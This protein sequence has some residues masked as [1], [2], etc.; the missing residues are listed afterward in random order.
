MQGCEEE[1]DDENGLTTFGNGGETW[2]EQ[3]G[4]PSRG[5][6]TALHRLWPAE[7][8]LTVLLF[9]EQGWT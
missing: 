4:L 9:N 2:S 1:E 3:D 8:N 7:Q 6:P 5:M